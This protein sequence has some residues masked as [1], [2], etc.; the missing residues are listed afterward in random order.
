MLLFNVFYS[1]AQEETHFT[2][3]HWQNVSRFKSSTLPSLLYVGDCASD[4]EKLP[5]S[6]NY[7]NETRSLLCQKNLKGTAES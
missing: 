3:R 2:Q 4:V 1:N 7:Q 6:I 5:F